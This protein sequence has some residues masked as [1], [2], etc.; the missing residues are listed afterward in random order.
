MGL[1]KRGITNIHPAFMEVGDGNGGGRTGT[2][3]GWR[4][5]GGMVGGGTARGR[6]GSWVNGQDADAWDEDT[7]SK[8]M[9][10]DDCHDHRSGGGGV[11]IPAVNSWGAI[12]ID[13]STSSG[14][15]LA[16]VSRASCWGGKEMQGQT[17]LCDHTY[18]HFLPLA[19]VR[20]PCAS[21]VPR[22]VRLWRAVS[23]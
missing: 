18:T 17:T 12:K 3:A 16:D 13:W 23:V 4:G 15:D 20:A 1:G 14:R 5:Y 6:A 19:C 22:R 2:G 10:V 21:S 9:V 11:A 8:E 7:M